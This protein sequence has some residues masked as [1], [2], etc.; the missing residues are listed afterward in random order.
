MARL[1]MVAHEEAAAARSAEITELHA[2]NARI[3]TLASRAQAG[4]TP[5]E[6]AAELRELLEPSDAPLRRAR[7]QLERALSREASRRLKRRAM[8]AMAAGLR[9][10]RDAAP[11]PPPPPLSPSS[12]FAGA[13]AGARPGPNAAGRGVEGR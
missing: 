5:E 9:E 4:R 13:A 7:E 11:P 8:D 3:A 2:A 10:V 1:R 12:A 6:A